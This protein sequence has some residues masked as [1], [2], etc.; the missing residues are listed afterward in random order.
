MNDRDLDIL[1][2]ATEIAARVEE[3]AQALAPEIDDDWVFVVLLQGATLFGMDLLRALARQGRHP[4]TDYLW[5]SSYGDAQESSGRV[6]VRAD[7]SA[8]VG[9]QGVLI[10]DDVFDTGRTLAFADDYVR[11]KGASAVKA[12][13][14][15]RK[16]AA[17][18]S[19]RPDLI[20]FDLPNRFLIGYGMDDRG[21]GRGLPW[22]GA[23][24]ES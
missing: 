1:L 4:R 2:S 20:G 22:I 19:Y 9:G 7:L 11:A 17:A 8:S 14:L 16:P 21:R 10:V 3:L 18:V 23:K 24:K 5:L 12:V 13:V 6:Q 15:A